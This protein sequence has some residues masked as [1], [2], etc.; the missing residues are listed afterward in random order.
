M[1]S[2]AHKSILLVAKGADSGFHRGVARYSKQAGWHLNLDCI[3]DRDFLWGWGGDGCIAMVRDP[4][5]IQFTKSLKIPTV[6]ITHERPNLFTRILE[7]NEAIGKLAAEYFI[8]LG[9]KHFATYTTDLGDISTIRQNTFTREIKK[10]GYETKTLLWKRREKRTAKD[11]L[12]R[13]DWLTR[14]LEA[15]PKPAAVFCIDDRMAINVIETCLECGISIPTDIATLGVGNLEIACECSVISL[16]SIRIDFENLGYQSAELLD[17]ILDGKK[18]PSEPILLPPL[19]IEERRST[20][21]LAV[22]D[23]SGQKAIRFMLDNFTSPISVKEIT[24]AGGLTRR[25]LT[26]ITEKELGI[27]PAKLLE[28]IRIKK[29]CELLS[30]T[31]HTVDRIANESGLKTALR[32]QRIF[33][34][35]FKTSPGAWRKT[36][37]PE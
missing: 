13:N 33:R 11:W 36:H 18:P 12:K 20:Y 8:G 26:Y 6:G 22:D 25:Q 19:G 30:T 31:N 16:S 35:R 1:N 34:I 7:D 9:F 37:L 29:A 24:Q 27:S 4:E 32:L 5:V 3:Y 10:A 23:P 14:E 21:T 2:K 17:Q 28:H 15:L